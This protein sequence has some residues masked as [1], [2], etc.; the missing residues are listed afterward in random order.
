[1]NSNPFG[2]FLRNKREEKG[3]SIRELSN[4][5]GLSHTYLSY[6]EKGK[7][8]PPNNSHLIMIAKA[9]GFDNETKS[10]FYDLAAESRLFYNREYSIPADI[11]KYISETNK[12]KDFIREAEQRGYSNDFWNEIL[13]KLKKENMSQ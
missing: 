6:I 7:K 1:M 4:K 8:Q 12:A 2:V 9:L 3:L 11:A 13:Q 10:L 5:V